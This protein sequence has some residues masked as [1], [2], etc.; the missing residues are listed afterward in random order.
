[1]ASVLATGVFDRARATD[2]TADN[3]VQPQSMTQAGVG[4]V[5]EGSAKYGEYNGLKDKGLFGIAN[6]DW[7]GGGAYDSSDATRWRVVGS[8]LGLNDRDLTAD[9]AVQGIYKIHFGAS[10]ITHWISDS[11][12]TPYQG[13]GGSYLSLPTTWLVPI[14]PQNSA[15]GFNFRALDPINGDGG[16][17]SNVKGPTLGTVT[18]PSAANL[19]TLAAIQ[20]ADDAAF[21]SVGLH[22]WRERYDV[23]GVI[24]LSKTWTLS[25]GLTYEQKS[26]LQAE[27]ALNMGGSPSSILPNLIDNRTTQTT[28]KLGYSAKS[29]Y[30]SLGYYGSIFQN[31][32]PEMTFQSPANLAINSDIS[33]APNNQYHQLGLNAGWHLTPTTQLVGNLAVG[34]GTQNQA[35]I[36]DGAGTLPL[37]LAATSLNG[38]VDTTT[39]TLRLSSHPIRHLNLTASYK[40]DSRVN[41]S[42]INTYM[43]YDAGE[44]TSGTSLFYPQLGSN[45][46]IYQNRDYSKRLNQLNLDADYGIGG[47]GVKLGYEWNRTD[48]W[49]H[50]SWINCADAPKSEENTGKID[51]RFAATDNVNGK[52][53]FSYS[54]RRVNYDADAFLALV[55]EAAVAT[56]GSV[57]NVSA[58]QYLLASGYTGFGP[59]AAYA[60]TAGNANLYF[61]NGSILANGTYGSRNAINEL[62]DLER[63]YA[64][65]RNRWKGKLL[66]NWDLSD[67]SS[68]QV[69]FSYLT[70][71]YPSSTY[72]LISSRGVTSD[73]DWSVNWS[74]A[75]VSTAYVTYERNRTATAGMSYGSSS[76]TGYVGGN[77][78]N[79]AVS[80][81]S[82]VSTVALKS[83]DA[84]IDP[85]LNWYTD[86]EDRTTTLG[87]NWKDRGFADGK[88]EWSLD[89]HYSFAMT[90]IGVNGGSYSNS[91][92]AV[93]NQAAVVSPAVYYITAQN[94]PE[95]LTRALTVGTH[96]QFHFSPYKTLA[97]GASTERFRNSDYIYQGMQLGSLS[98]VMPTMESAPNFNVTT[99]AMAYTYRFH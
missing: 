83:A 73:L 89:A 2:S 92:L 46:N 23:S 21:H 55:P 9:Y 53:G 45:I 88:V 17:I 35:F 66:T 49:C 44:S 31:Q 82:C 76:S 33:N 90:N 50:D 95:V 16:V 94:M 85:C 78:A 86:S 13:I 29:I 30:F 80:G 8:N 56:P 12:Q 81:S 52:M 67:D 43:F 64:A 75:R 5:S 22:T 37:G 6:I 27:G 93:S 87:V 32:V 18:A 40:F 24:N 20:A 62:P 77:K 96:L 51:F 74:E 25:G 11:Y 42:P 41:T 19:S 7:R 61:P 65:D 59:L 54:A 72:G 69:T 70:D 28:V 4:D 47:Q 97:I 84:K 14:V 58:Y 36:N 99:I 48:R 57:G 63:F 10:E 26:G 15:S 98:S 39:A 1:M 71:D 91:P 79:T 38:E 60:A 34:R 68:L 3:L